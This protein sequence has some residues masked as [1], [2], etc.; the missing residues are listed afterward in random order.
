MNLSEKFKVNV[1][2]VVHEMIE[3][4]VVIVNLD[5]GDYYS[6]L[7]AG[8]DIWDGLAR[9]LSRGEI[10]EEIVSRYE[11]DRETMATAVNNLIE[12]LQREALITVDT[13]NGSNQTPI[14]N[15]NSSSNVSEKL[16]FDAPTLNKYTDME[17]LL[18]LDPIHEVDQEMGWPSAKV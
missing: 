14:A 1:P 9:G 18:A 8:A 12:E 11:S 6:L 2:K 10:V 7:K 15:G 16:S 4:E 3:G 17:E 13:T 5:G